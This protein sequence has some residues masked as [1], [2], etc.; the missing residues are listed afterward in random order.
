MNSLAAGSTEKDRTDTLCPKRGLYFT[1]K[2]MGAY[3]RLTGSIVFTGRLRLSFSLFHKNLVVGTH[4][5]IALSKAKFRFHADREHL[6]G[7]C[8]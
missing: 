2:P 6:E 1:G 3:Q 7:M 4:R 5:F 8:P